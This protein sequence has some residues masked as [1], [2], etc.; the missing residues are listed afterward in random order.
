MTERFDAVHPGHINVEKHKVDRALFE[1]FESLLSVLRHLDIEVDSLETKFE[2]HPEAVFV[3]YNKDFIFHT[4]SLMICR[5]NVIYS[6]GR[7]K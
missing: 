4:G 6:V 2:R 7:V 3:V 5:N 1:N